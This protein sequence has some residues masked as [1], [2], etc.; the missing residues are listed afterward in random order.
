MLDSISLSIMG[1]FVCKITRFKMNIKEIYNVAVHC[2]TLPIILNIAYILLNLFTGFKILNFSIM[3]IIIACIYLIAAILII[4][5]DI[6]KRNIELMKIIEEQAKIRLEIKK[7]ELEKKQQEEKEKVKKK[8]KKEEKKN[9]DNK[10]PEVD[11]TPE[12]NNA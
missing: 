9:K 2:L 12:G 1:Y 3:Y 7:R 5:D 8:D 11:E 4:R 6:N 10:E